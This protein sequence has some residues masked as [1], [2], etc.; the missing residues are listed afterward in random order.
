MTRSWALILLFP[1]IRKSFVDQHHRNIILDGIEK[2]TGFANQTISRSIQ[3]DISFTFRTSQNFQE[4]FT[5]G[6]LRSPF[7]NCFTFHPLKSHFLLKNPMN[8]LN[9]I[10]RH[11]IGLDLPPVLA[12]FPFSFS[13]SRQNQDGLAPNSAGKFNIDSSIPNHITL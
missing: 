5:D 2:V 4:L 10:F 13:I 9:E 12:I 6:H 7:L 3:E 11:M 1:L 8:S